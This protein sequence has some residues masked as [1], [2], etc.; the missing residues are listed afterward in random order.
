LTR[1]FHKGDVVLVPFPFTDLSAAKLRPA[2]ILSPDPE[3]PDFVVA[4]VSSITP[5]GPLPLPCLLIPTDHPEFPATGLKRSSV[6]RLDKLLT[7]AR[8]RDQRR[9]GHLG[10]SPISGLDSRFRATFRL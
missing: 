8:S 1:R 6:V 3:G 4:Y 2:V 9:L 5:A 7:I 10:P